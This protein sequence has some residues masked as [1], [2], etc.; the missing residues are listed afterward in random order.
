MASVTVRAGDGP[1]RYVVEVADRGA[2]TTHD[3]T[4]PAGFAAS[5]GPSGVDDERLVE[6]SFAFLLE[7]E[8]PSSILS[9]FSLSDI[10]I[11]FPDYPEVLVGRLA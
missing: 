9:R 1:G 4:V 11:Y 8:P 10:A 2:T 5:L 6:A 7:R 3:V